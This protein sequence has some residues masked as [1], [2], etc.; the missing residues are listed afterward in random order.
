MSLGNILFGNLIIPMSYYLRGDF[1]FKYFGEYKKNLKKTK[2]E[3]R[4]Y[5]FERLKKLILH[6]YETV[7][8]YKALFDKIRLKPEDIKNLEDFKKIPPLTKKDV[9]ANYSTLK[10]TKKYRE[11]EISSGGSTGNRVV[12]L[13]DKRYHEISRAVVLRDLFSAGINPGSKIAWVWGSPIENTPLKTNIMHRMQWLIN[14]RIIF[15]TF[16]YTE[17]ELVTWLTTDLKSFNPD[18]I[19][20]YADAIIDI[21]KYIKKKEVKLILPNL[22][23]VICTAQKLEN[24]ELIEEA[25]NCKV[26]DHYGSREV[27]S[28][29]IEDENYL[30]H[31]SDDFVI[32]EIDEKNEII[33]TPLESYGMPL[34]RYKNGDI[35]FVKETKGNSSHPFNEFNIKV[36]RSVEI[37]RTKDG[38]RVYS[39]K[40]NRQIADQKLNIGELQLIQKSFEEAILNIVKSEQTDE[41]DV[42]KL[43]RIIKETLGTSTVKVQ[44]LSSFPIEKSGKKISYKCLIK[45]DAP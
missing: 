39:G 25:F 17:N 11:I 27:E 4:A 32:V 24:R 30:M 33:L 29:A 21:S 2:K 16:S 6:S 26:I 19:Y 38:K 5:Q 42:E 15:N 35:G 20:G 7:P 10:S 37:L 36:G 23:K 13:K 45:D 3:I 41:N 31:S 8:Y 22:K 12:V 9:L 44:Y 14:R 40:I 34:L 28:I 1:R 43:I 18:F